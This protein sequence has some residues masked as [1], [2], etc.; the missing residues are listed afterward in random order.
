M[1]A[2]TNTV[3]A[4]CAIFEKN[5]LFKSSEI[6]VLKKNFEAQSEIAFEDFL[7]EESLISKEHLL[8]ALSELYQVPAIDVVGLFFDHNI[9]KMFPKDVMLRNIFI[10]YE[11]DGDV[12]VVIAYNPNNNALSEIIGEYVSYDVTY[13]VGLP[14]DICDAIKEFFDASLQQQEQDFVPEE[15][16]EEE[17]DQSFNDIV[18]LE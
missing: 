16:K 3:D 4:L 1:K 12:L 7:L 9:V 18:N 8:E 13:M 14:R 10:P 17:D 5:N 6:S 11:H 2:F 15:V